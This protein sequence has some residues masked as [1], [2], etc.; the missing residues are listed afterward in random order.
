[1][2]KAE[3]RAK[4]LRQQKQAEAERCARMIRERAAEEAAR[5]ERMAPAVLADI[6]KLVPKQQKKEVNDGWLIHSVRMKPDG[7][8]MSGLQCS[9]TFF[10]WLD[11]RELSMSAVRISLRPESVMAC[12][13]AAGA[14]LGD[15]TPVVTAAMGME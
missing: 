2:P 7:S 11:K 5:L 14:S 8:Y 3:R 10:V 13:S 12:V 15:I 4:E 1:M 9:P 6:R